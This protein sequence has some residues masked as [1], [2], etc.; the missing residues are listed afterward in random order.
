MSQPEADRKRIRL[1]VDWPQDL[2]KFPVD[3][4]LMYQVFVNLIKNGLEAVADGGSLTVTGEVVKNRFRVTVSDTGAGMDPE[5][6]NRVFEPFF[7]T[8]GKKGTGLGLSVVRTVVEAH[9]GT[10][11]CDSLK[12]EGTRFTINLP[13]C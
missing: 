7:T 3:A 12:G 2:P 10:I 11:T 5:T 8:K 4:R 13:V 1:T 6:A 9:R